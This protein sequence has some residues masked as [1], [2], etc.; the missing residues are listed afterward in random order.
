MDPA[1]IILITNAALALLD[2]YLPKVKEMLD[3]GDITPE[4]QAALKAR[5]AA[6]RSHDAFAGPE[7]D[8]GNAPP[9]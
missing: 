8:T 2:E 4:Q 5:I 1:T 6:L 3:S 7:W 9:A